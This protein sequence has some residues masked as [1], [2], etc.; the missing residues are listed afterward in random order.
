MGLSMNQEGKNLIDLETKE[1]II[2]IIT[3]FIPDA[4]IYLFGSRARGTASKWSDI[5]I[6]LDAG[7]LLPNVAIDE[8]ISVFQATNIPY[9]IEIVDFHKVNNDMQESISREGILWKP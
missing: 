8:I 4:K 5:D 9:K 1:K 7:K 3:T 6:A 2:K